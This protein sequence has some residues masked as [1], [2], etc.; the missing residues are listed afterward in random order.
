MIRSVFW[1]PLDE[2]GLEHLLFERTPDSLRADSVILQTKNGVSFRLRYQIE[3]ASDWT[4]RS[5][6]V[7]VDKGR[8]LQRR[9]ELRVDDHGEW[10]DASTEQKLPALAGCCEVDIQVTPFTNSLP[11]GRL[12]LA[13]GESQDV[14]AAYVE[15]PELIVTPAPQRY[16]ALTE[17]R[18]RYEGLQSGFAAELSLDAEGLVIDYAGVFVRVS[19]PIA[20]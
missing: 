18:F 6:T 10:H 16:T 5:C 19:R 13:P 17:D 14:L 4:M 20:A 8:D 7:A 15:V 1:R 9:L 12:K 11:I 3:T 2:I